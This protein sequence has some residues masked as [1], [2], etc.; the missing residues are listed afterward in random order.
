MSHEIRRVLRAL[1]ARVWFIEPGKAAEIISILE[2]RAAQGPR[3]ERYRGESAAPQPMSSEQGKIAVIRLHGVIAPRTSMMDDLCDSGLVSLEGFQAAF[4]AVANDPS[5]KAIILDVDSPGGMVDLVPETAAKIRKARRADRP[6]VA[7]ANTLAASA[8]YWIASAADEI[9]VT[10]SG[11]VGSIGVYT[12]HQ[13]ISE[14]CK[15]EGIAVTFI[16]E[17]ARKVEANPFEPLSA[18]ASAALQ[19]NVRHY[20][21]MFTKDVARA[22]GVEIAVVRG[23]PEKDEKH[24]G[25]GRCYPANI[26]VDLGMADS[27]DTLETTIARLADQANTAGPVKKRRAEIE[28]RRLALI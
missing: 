13:D 7:V 1:A 5:V 22:R 17:G 4:D 23:D 28:R 12:M 24:F 18:E 16:F 21:D 26:A 20:Y 25:G 9:I 6:I 27:V 14:A 3:A 11:E 19:Q 10:P 2:W 8:A 15:M